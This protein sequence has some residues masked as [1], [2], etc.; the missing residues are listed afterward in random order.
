VCRAS[1]P[2]MCQAAQ[3]RLVSIDRSFPGREGCMRGRR[4]A[5]LVA[6]G[7]AVWSVAAEAQTYPA[8][9]ITI[10]VPYAAGGV[11]DT[12]ARIIGVRMGELLGRSE[13]HTSELQ[14]LTNL[15]CRL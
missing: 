11:F 7:V 10:V 1:V 6:A 12:M 15:V 9:P 3:G 2:W 8:R 5:L 13:E 4:L 14:S